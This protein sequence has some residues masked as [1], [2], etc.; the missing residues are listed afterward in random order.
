MGQV[1]KPWFDP[2]DPT[3]VRSG[4]SNHGSIQR[5]EQLF[6][7]EDPTMRLKRFITYEK[8]LEKGTTLFL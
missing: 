8:N 4:G 2:L 5:I 1:R 3:I 7:P 6:D